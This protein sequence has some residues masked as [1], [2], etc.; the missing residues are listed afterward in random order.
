MQTKTDAELLGEYAAKHSEAAFSEIVRRYANAVYSAAMRQVGSDAQARDVAQI[1][2]VDLAR[3]AASLNVNTL[4]IGWLHRGARL[5]ALELLRKEQRRDRRERQAME[6]HDPAPESDNWNAVRPVLDEA[7]ANLGKEDRAALLLRFFRNESLASVGTTLGVSEDA[8]QKRVS[9]A[10]GKL[11][12]FLEQRGIKTTAAALS[13]A[14]TANAVQSAPANFAASL[15]AGALAKAAIAGS[16]PTPFL[17]ILTF[18]NMKTA[19]LILTLAGGFA[20][21]TLVKVQSQHRLRDAQTLVQQQAEEIDALRA[22]NEQLASQTNELARLRGEAREV[23]RLRGEVTQLRR[24]AA[25]RKA[26]V[27][28]MAP[29]ETNV[30]SVSP[31][32]QI[33]IKAKFVTVPE[34]YFGAEATG[35]LTDPQ[36]RTVLKALQQ[37]DGKVILSDLQVTT[38]SGHQA[39]VSAVEAISLGDGITNTGP[40]LNVIPTCATNSYTIQLDLAAELR[41][42]VDMSPQRDGSQPGIQYTATTNS[43]SVW[44]GQTI[45][46]YRKISGQGRRLNGASATTVA[47]RRG[48]VVFVTPTIIDPA[49]NRRFTDEEVSAAQPTNAPAS[50]FPGQVVPQT[51]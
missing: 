30:P 25:D 8:A 7:I 37:V 50:A 21:I 6:F 17:R 2:F 9:R 31:E 19:V 24:T 33:N 12:D 49:G 29:L 40:V 47:E 36:F 44:D 1:V 43:V 34:G 5:A 18:T 16:S 35:I 11:R 14:L 39:E 13:A 22:A 23:L 4:L 28:Q 27:P 15:T 48:L 42:L 45:M 46:L 32:P 10:L 26:M 51:E 38:L 20:G 3:K 41:E